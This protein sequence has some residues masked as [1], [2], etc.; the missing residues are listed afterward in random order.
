MN[1]TSIN[2]NNAREEKT[3]RI[4]VQQKRRKATIKKLTK[5]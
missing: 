3:N 5:R 2:L 4:A 1:N